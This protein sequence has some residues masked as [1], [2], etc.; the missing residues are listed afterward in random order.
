MKHHPRKRFGQHFLVDF[1]IIDKIVAA[2]HPKRDQHVIEIGPG[3]GA[4]TQA[5]VDVA[6]NMEAVEL[7]RDLIQ[8]L[9]VKFPQLKLHQ[10]DALTFDFCQL[11]STDQPLRIVGNLPYN[12]STPLLFH[13]FALKKCILDMHFM[14]QKEVV[15]RLQAQPGTEHYGRLSVMAQYHCRIVK[16]FEVPP[17]A[18]N[19]PPKVDSAVVRYETILFEAK[20]YAYFETIVREAFN[21]RRKT[22]RNSLKNYISET[23]LEEINI[24]PQIRPEQLSVEAFV[25]IANKR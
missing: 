1:N 24:D 17:E 20:D 7:D 22:L 21:H 14:L 9:L 4:L 12:I 10:G 6:P 16:L 8:L 18:F 13:L 25:L 15:D 11:A 3:E 19:P 5:L 23:E 2:I